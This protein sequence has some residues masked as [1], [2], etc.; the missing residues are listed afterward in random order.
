MSFWNYLS[1]SERA[2]YITLLLIGAA[3]GVG[4][5][6]LG[7]VGRLSALAV[8]LIIT[9]VFVPI[10][11]RALKIKTATLK[12]MSPE[13]L[14]E[15]EKKDLKETEEFVKLGESFKYSK[16]EWA[17]IIFVFVVCI[18]IAILGYLCIY[19]RYPEIW[20]IVQGE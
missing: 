8:F 6:V 15:K 10:A 17:F 18:L 1:G 13:E 20:K 4:V 2:K 3:I 12:K 11:T 7:V 14:S 16:K 5:V 19:L 9:S